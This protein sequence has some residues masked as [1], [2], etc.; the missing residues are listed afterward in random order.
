MI[1]L[2]KEKKVMARFRANTD[3]KKK[4]NTTQEKTFFHLSP[5]KYFMLLYI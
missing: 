4:E 1:N 3:Y 5:S 2:K